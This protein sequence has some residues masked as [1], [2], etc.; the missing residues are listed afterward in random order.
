M[1]N[2]H[3]KNETD[4]LINA[5]QGILTFS[6]PLINTANTISLN[7]NNLITTTGGQTIGGTLTINSFLILNGKII[8]LST[9]VGAPETG[10][11]AGNGAKIVNFQGTSTTYAS[12][13]GVDT[14][15]FWLLTPPSKTFNFYIGSSSIFSL[16][17][18]TSTL[19]G[20]LNLGSTLNRP[21][22]LGWRRIEWHRAVVRAALCRVLCRVESRGSLLSLWCG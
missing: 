3:S 6:S 5:K 21:I 13:I 12:V 4:L 15:S 14:S 10:T 9:T 7:T 20:I 18:T 1:T 22:R 17:S 11:N 8:S 16:G 19:S 2:I